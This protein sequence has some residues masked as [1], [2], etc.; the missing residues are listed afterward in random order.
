MSH[1]G[2]TNPSLAKQ[3]APDKFSVEL[4]TTKGSIILDVDRALAPNGADRFY[5]LVTVGYYTD[6]AFFRVVD[7]FMAQVGLHGE[8]SINKTWRDHRIQDDPVRTSNKRGT[9]SYATSGPN[10]RTSQFFINY[11]DNGRLDSMGFSPFATVRD[12]TVADA[13]YAG[14]GDGPPS[15]RGPQQGRIH[16][17][18]NN[19]LKGEFGQLDFIKSAR[20][21]E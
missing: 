21:I 18:G 7:N 14:Y 5:N 1:E 15:G 19:Y 9:V 2:L 16:R 11:K 20:V 10:A 6:I 3:T 4:D 17:E 13:L 8:P 12:M